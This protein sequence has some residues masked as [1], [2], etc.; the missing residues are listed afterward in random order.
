MDCSIC[1]STIKA[2]S[3]ACGECG[4]PVRALAPFSAADASIAVGR[5][6]S[7]SAAPLAVCSRCTYHGQGMPYFSRGTHIA[8]LAAATFFTL[9]W[10]LGGGGIL[11]YALRKDHR[12]CPRCGQG[13]GKH[14][15]YALRVIEGSSAPAPS[16]EAHPLVPAESPRRTA[17]VL[18]GVLGAILFTIGLV[19]FEVLL[20]AFGLLS[21]GGAFALHRAA[22]RARE[23]RREALIGALQSPVLKLAAERRGRL[24]VTDVST[25]LGWPMRRAEKVLHSLDDGWRVASEV[26]DEGV[27]VYEFR[28]LLLLRHDEG[29][30]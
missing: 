4:E 13:W 17:S 27:I 11:Y 26:T 5:V 15:E 21:G 22:N 7:P 14:S 29:E 30:E 20:L 16:P 23:E 10:A 18:L 1:G 24:T 28:E 9:P 8:G 25:A 19:Q 6:L 12:I 2:G 3:A